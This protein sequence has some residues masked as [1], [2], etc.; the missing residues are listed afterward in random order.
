MSSS[1]FPPAAPNTIA[2]L[3]ERIAKLEAENAK[4][5]GNVAKL[6]GNVAKL[7]GDM[8]CLDFLC[9]L[10]QQYLLTLL[11]ITTMISTVMPI[12]T[13][14]MYKAMCKLLFGWKTGRHKMTSIPD[15]IYNSRSEFYKIGLP[16]EEEMKEFADTYATV[17]GDR[18]TIA[19]STTGDDIIRCLPYMDETVGKIVTYGSPIIFNCSIHD[20]ESTSEEN[21]SKRIYNCMQALLNLPYLLDFY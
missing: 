1:N 9:I 20:W 15:K 12:N 4:L 10:V 2:G 3:C 5:N 6:N 21:K 18:N 13:A 16:S 14:V 19:H 11:K 8:V 17:V 7:N